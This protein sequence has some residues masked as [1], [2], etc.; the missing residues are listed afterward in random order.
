MTSSACVSVYVVA[1]LNL[2]QN[3]IEINCFEK[4]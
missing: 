1:R 2:R 4:V 3:K